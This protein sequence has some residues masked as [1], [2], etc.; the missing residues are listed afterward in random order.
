[1]VPQSLFRERIGGKI[2]N[3]AFKL[4]DIAH[5][6]TSQSTESSIARCAGFG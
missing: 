1:M 4:L 6:G 3:L 5:D 2:L